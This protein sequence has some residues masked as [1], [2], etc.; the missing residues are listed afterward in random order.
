MLIFGEPHKK[1]TFVTTMSQ[2][3]GIA[4]NKMSIGPGHNNSTIPKKSIRCSA[5]VL[6]HCF[7]PKKV[8]SKAFSC[9]IFYA[10][11][12]IIKLLAWSDPVSRH[13]L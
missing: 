7:Y 2:M 3:P 9:N 4:G 13:Y 8:H 6:E 11:D 5:Y 10:F 1:F 12:N